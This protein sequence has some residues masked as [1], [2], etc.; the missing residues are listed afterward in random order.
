M[1][2]SAALLAPLIVLAST[3]SGGNSISSSASLVSGS[4]AL[5][6]FASAGS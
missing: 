5:S 2:A 1:A 3:G 6:G 4:D